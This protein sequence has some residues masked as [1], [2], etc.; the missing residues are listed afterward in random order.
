[1]LLIT[2]IKLKEKGGKPS[3]RGSCHSTTTKLSPF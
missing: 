2:M 1:M 3:F